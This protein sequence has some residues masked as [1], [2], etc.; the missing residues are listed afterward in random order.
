M[1]VTDPPLTARRVSPAFS[2]SVTAAFLGVYVALLPATS[3]TLA[4]RVQQIDPAGKAGSLSLVLGVGALV[5]LLAQN[6]FGTLSDRT[7][8]R[9]GMRTPW[10]AAGAVLGAAS[11]AGLAAAPTIPL[12]TLAWAT[13]QLT[14]NIL[15]AGLNPVLP[16]HVPSAQLGRLSGIVGVTTQV[17]AVIGVFLV[18]ELL[19]DLHLAILLPAVP[20]LL[21]VGAF[22]FVLKDRRLEPGQRRPFRLKEVVGSYW[23]S[24]RRHPDF[25]WA[26]VSRLLV[27]FGNFTLANYQVYFLQHRFG[28]SQTDVGTAVLQATLIGT[29][30]TLLAAY[31]F[32]ALSDRMGRRKLFVVLSAGVLALAH[33]LAAFA[34]G[35]GVYLVAAAVAGVA[36]GCY[37][38]VD[39]ALVAEVLPSREDIGKDMGV[40]HLANVLPQTLVPVVAPAFLA[41]GGGEN[42]V[43]LLVAGT[44]VGA[45]GALAIQPV[46]SVR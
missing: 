4:L 41:I 37:L 8:S 10:I 7:T 3:V 31:A 13:V 22:L 25:A 12:L 46:R 30:C 45:V 33:L 6:V 1:S 20:C 21:L 29:G 32:G 26:W 9:F 2:V 27:F 23:A 35:L 14:F 24:P 34:P 44:V 18:R 15:L 43:A 39:L 40:F 5:A 19:P 38:A 17:S 28:L 36:M 42:Y 16:D 11:L